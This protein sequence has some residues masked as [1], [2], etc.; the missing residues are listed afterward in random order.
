MEQDR[1]QFKEVLPVAIVSWTGALLEWLDFYTYAILAKT[2]AKVYFPSHDPLASL[3]ASFAALAIG[4]LFRPVGAL[5]FGKI[6]DQY[7][8]KI[9]FLT[10]ITM[11]MVGTIGIAVLPS[12]EAIGVLASIGV[13]IL[14]IIQ[15]LALGGGYGAAITYLGEFTPITEEGSSQA[16]FLQLLP[17]V[18]HLLQILL[19]P[20]RVILE[21]RLLRLQGGDGAL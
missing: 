9:A 8:R 13:F 7:G 21:Q 2:L 6:G 16:F 4:F 18:W 10:A 3:L 20:F 12:Y 17:L 11:M 19:Q 14:R 1:V 5:M 15:G